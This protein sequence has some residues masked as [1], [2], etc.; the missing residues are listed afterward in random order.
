M[1]RIVAKQLYFLF[2]FLIVSIATSDV[3]AL[4]EKWKL[5]EEEENAYIEL[6]SPMKTQLEFWLRNV[7]DTDEGR[8]FRALCWGIVLSD[9]RSPKKFDVE[10]FKSLF[11]QVGTI[12]S[13]SSAPESGT[14]LFQN[15]IFISGEAFIRVGY[16]GTNK[17]A[18]ET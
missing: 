1:K 16:E 10:Q 4:D 7:P 2:I 18:G 3:W 17:I 5:K 8:S 13:D 9:H 15:V 12:R 11:M 14:D 6:Y